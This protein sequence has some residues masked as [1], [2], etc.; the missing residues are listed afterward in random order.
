M[1]EIGL[2]V[3]SVNFQLALEAASKVLLDVE[4]AKHWLAT[5]PISCLDNMTGVALIA[6]GRTSDLLDYLTSIE[7]GFV[8]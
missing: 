1:N 5:E 8:G 4:C 3:T 6:S 2:D 7:A